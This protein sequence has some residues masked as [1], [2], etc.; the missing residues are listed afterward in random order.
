MAEVFSGFV[1]GYGLS[2]AFSWLAA[3]M[4]LEARARSPYLGRAI[5]AN[6]NVFMLS[7]PISILAFLFWT[8]LGMIMGLLY[9]GAEANIPAGGLGSPNLVFT[10][11]VAV[12][13]LTILAVAWY[14]WQ[15]F[16]PWRVTAFVV[17]SAALFGWAMP[18][19]SRAAF[20]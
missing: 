6:I 10:M 16:P 9:R 15:R 14:A 3:V 12:S 2:L 8:A 4:L 11:S 5:S 19:M 18:Y 1:I 20:D 17:L 13:G 7:I